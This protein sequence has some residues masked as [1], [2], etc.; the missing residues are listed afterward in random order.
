MSLWHRILYWLGIR[1]DPGPRYYLLDETIYDALQDL[2][3]RQQRP[4]K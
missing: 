4:P 2:A 1:L 3:E